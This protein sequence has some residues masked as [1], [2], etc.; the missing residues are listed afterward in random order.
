VKV[1]GISATG[2]EPSSYPWTDLVLVE[3]KLEV[4][5]YLNVS[6]MFIS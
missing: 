4:A 3:L 1:L 5:Y 6:A 2:S